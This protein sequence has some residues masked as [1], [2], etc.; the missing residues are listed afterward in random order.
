MR[1]LFFMIFFLFFGHITLTICTTLQIWYNNIFGT[2]LPTDML[3][4]SI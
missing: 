2:E 3:K 1:L 4:W